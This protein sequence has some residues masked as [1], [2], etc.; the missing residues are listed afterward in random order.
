MD[1]AQ[2]KLNLSEREFME[3]MLL[4]TTA[5]AHKLLRN[6]SHKEDTIPGMC[7][8]LILVY[9]H[10]MNPEEVKEKLPNFKISNR[11]NI[12]RA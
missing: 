5:S 6:L 3:R 12:T 10:T 1:M 7:H 4:S 8:K 2:E 9:D 11:S